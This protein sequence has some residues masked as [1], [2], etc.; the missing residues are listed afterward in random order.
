MGLVKRR[1][2]ALWLRQTRTPFSPRAKADQYA[3]E[4]FVE[5]REP[6]P[7][8]GTVLAPGKYVFRP[9]DR[10]TG[11]NLVQIFNEHKTELVATFTVANWPSLFVKR[12]PEAKELP[13]AKGATSSRLVS[14]KKPDVI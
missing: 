12:S 8:P 5:V 2:N 1:L 6:L 9:P 7:I 11:C 4:M 14:S 3:P 13:A 10:G